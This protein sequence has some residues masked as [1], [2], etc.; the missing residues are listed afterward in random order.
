MIS[1][2][3]TAAAAGNR[4]LLALPGEGRE[5]LLR[6]SEH[7]ALAAGQTLYNAGGQIRHVYFPASGAVATAVAM[8]DGSQVEVCLTG[9][10]GFVG[11]P[12]LLG[13]RAASNSRAVVLAAGEA[14]RVGAETFA[15]EFADAEPFRGLVLRYVLAL[16]EEVSQSSA[17]HRLHTVEARLARWLLEF[18]DRAGRDELILTHELIAAM[19]GVRREGVTEI[20]G[21]LTRDGLISH[22][23]CRIIFRDRAGLEARACECYQAV[24]SLL[25]DLYETGPGVVRQRFYGEATR[26]LP[27]E[28]R[29]SL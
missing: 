28:G 24:K 26:R 17:C 23:R 29:H 11:L 9:R 10:E 27:A 7:V 22:C 3:A 13:H 15:R 12:A 14:V 20:V 25:A 2:T 16:V 6:L 18:G 21:R 4:L 5:R 8:E 1:E 19:L